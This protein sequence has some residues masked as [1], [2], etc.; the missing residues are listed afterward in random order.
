MRLCFSVGLSV[1][2]L[3]VF[4]SESRSEGLADSQTRFYF[5][6]SKTG[7]L[8]SARIVRHYWAR[9]MVHPQATVDPRLDPALRRAATI[10]DEHANARSKMRCWRYVKKALVE[11]GACNS[12]PHT[13]YAYEA[14]EE[15]VRHY[16][17]RRLSIRDPYSAPIGAVLV[18]GPGIDNDAG[19]VAIRTKNGFASDYR[20]NRRCRYPL[21][22]IYGKFPS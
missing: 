7:K 5:R 13:Q 9:P 19:H 17:F 4:V 10:A 18:Y 21:L 6:D 8:S 3:L 14:G 20:T 12:Y 15:L 1:F 22:A 2:A 11:S 16:G